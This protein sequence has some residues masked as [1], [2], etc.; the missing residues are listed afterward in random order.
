MQV[1]L[2]EEIVREG[3][4]VRTITFPCP[5]CGQITSLFVTDGPRFT[6][7][8]DKEKKLWHNV[9][10]YKIEMGKI[11]IVPSINFTVGNNGKPFYPH[12]VKCHFFITKQEVVEE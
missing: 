2:G 4:K 10:E 3:R 11:T 9:W 7:H 6:F 12:S 1:F 8:S 5:G